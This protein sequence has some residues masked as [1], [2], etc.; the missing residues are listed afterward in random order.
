MV[1]GP[2]SSD[3]TLIIVCLRENWLLEKSLAKSQTVVARTASVRENEGEVPEHFSNT[4]TL[5]WRL[6]RMNRWALAI[7]ALL[8]GAVGLLHADYVV[9]KI[10][11]A[12]AKEKQDEAGQNTQGGV[13]GS[14]PLAPG[15]QGPGV[16]GGPGMQP[17]AGRFPGFGQPGQGRFGPGFGPGQGPGPGGARGPAYGGPAYGG[18]PGGPGPGMGRMAGPGGMGSR[19]PGLPG[20]PGAGGSGYPGYGGATYGRS[21]TSQQ[22]EDEPDSVPLFVGAVIEVDHKD[23][24]KLDSGRVQIKQKWGHTILYLGDEV[25]WTIYGVDT[26]AQ[27]FEARKRQIKRNDPNRAE[28]LLALADW[29]LTHGLLD[30]VPK[31]MDEVAKLDPKQP[32]VAAFQKVHGDLER[33]ASQ[34]DAAAS[35]RQRL[36]DFKKKESKH[37]TLLYDVPTDTQ[38]QSFLDE[39]ERNYRGF[40]YWFALRGTIL[41]LPDHRLVAVLVDSPEAFEHQHKDIFDDPVMVADGFYSPRDNLAVFSVKRLDEGYDALSQMTKNIWDLTHLSEDELLKGKGLKLGPIYFNESAKAQTLTLVRKAMEE[42]GERATVTHEGTR[43]LISAIGLMPRSVEPP[44]WIDFG[45]ASFFETPKGS[46]WPGTGAP[47]MTYLLNFKLWDYKKQ[48][49]KDPV[50]ALKAVVTD[51]NFHK[52]KD[53]KNKENTEAKARTMAWALVYFLAHKK[54]DGLLR[55]YEELAKQPRDLDLDE[56]VL[57]GCFARAFGLVDPKKPNEVDANELNKLAL[58]WY[59]FIKDTPLEIQEVLTEALAAQKKK[60]RNTVPV[61]GSPRIPRPPADNPPGGGQGGPPG[62]GQGRP[63]G[64]GN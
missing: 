8:G 53:S 30:Q 45:M 4:E 22:E 27:K 33:G 28:Q 48:L 61:Y 34:A 57:L 47:N 5:S 55:Y 31:L 40:F 3:Y 59:K 58:S 32:A 13:A 2:A 24:K 54:R 62:G 43:Q 21:F 15:F 50:E 42:D 20:G 10:N 49:D 35:W 12:N 37:Y 38:A 51:R 56:D 1:K 14:N 39:L 17:G 36:G 29:S 19:G 11:L 7:A 60:G 52:I 16:P 6:R 46:Y 25:E 26:V 18:A 41:P 9:I 23:V 64:G 63:P 44:Q